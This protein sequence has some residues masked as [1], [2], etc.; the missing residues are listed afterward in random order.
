[1]LLYVHKKRSINL[2]SHSLHYGSFCTK[3]IVLKSSAKNQGVGRSD[4]IIDLDHYLIVIWLNF[5]PKELIGIWLI[6]FRIEWSR[7]DHFIRLKT[8]GNPKMQGGHPKKFN[9]RT[10]PD[11]R[12]IQD[13]PT[14]HCLNFVECFSPTQTG[15]QSCNSMSIQNWK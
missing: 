5:S 6:F 14:V 10:Q 15:H 9:P 11:S 8:L 13:C 3:T 12:K 4:L 1:M 7:S 2:T